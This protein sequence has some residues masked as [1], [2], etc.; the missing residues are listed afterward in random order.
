MA[1]RITIKASSEEIDKRIKDT[2]KRGYKLV[3][4]GKFEKNLS[5]GSRARNADYKHRKI[6]YRYYLPLDREWA[7]MEKV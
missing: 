2:E 5:T 4:R 6:D 3:K 1:F 7:V